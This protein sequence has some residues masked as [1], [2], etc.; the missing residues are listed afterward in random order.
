MWLAVRGALQLLQ[1]SSF[2][3]VVMTISIRGYDGPKYYAGNRGGGA[4]VNELAAEFQKRLWFRLS[5]GL[6]HL[7]SDL[8]QYSLDVYPNSILLNPI[9]RNT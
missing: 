4:A 8:D 3:K 2:R 1:T 9:S 7:I 6:Q 5:F